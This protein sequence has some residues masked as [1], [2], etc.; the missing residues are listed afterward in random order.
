MSGEVST[1]IPMLAV[2]NA[3]DA[4]DFYKEIFGANEV[5]RMVNDEGKVEHSEIKI[6]KSLIMIADE[7][8]GHN[9]SAKSLGGTP[10]I[11]HLYVDDVD[12]VVKRAVSLGSISLRPIKDLPHGERVGKIEDPF[13][14]VWMVAT[15]I[16]SNQN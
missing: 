13:G 16:C 12:D 4:I 1:I 14:L 2:H 3:N 6:G 7:F 9:R 15:P 11:I 8:P 5:I 10:V